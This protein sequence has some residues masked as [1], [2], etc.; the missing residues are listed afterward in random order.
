MWDFLQKYLK[1]KK[2]YEVR[3]GVVIL[4]DYYITEKYIDETDLL[5]ILA[6]YCKIYRL[7]LYLFVQIVA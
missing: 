4:L 2:E 1:S 6:A 3:F 7:I 5:T